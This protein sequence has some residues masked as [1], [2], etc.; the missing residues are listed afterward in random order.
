M[1]RFAGFVRVKAVVMKPVPEAGA[2]M[3]GAMPAVSAYQQ[4]LRPPIQHIVQ[5]KEMLI[6]TVCIMGNKKG[7]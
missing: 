5:D 6:E 1:A 7:Q 2:V 3:A 4:G